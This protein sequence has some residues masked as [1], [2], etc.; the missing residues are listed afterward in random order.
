VLLSLV[1]AALAT[2]NLPISGLAGFGAYKGVMIF[3]LCQ[4]GLDSTQL[5]VAL[6]LLT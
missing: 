1:L 6:H 3:T 5:P 4:A 2:A